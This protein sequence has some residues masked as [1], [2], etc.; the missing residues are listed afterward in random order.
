VIDLYGLQTA[1]REWS[2]FFTKLEAMPVPEK[3]VELQK[4]NW[5]IRGWNFTTAMAK[6]TAAGMKM[7]SQAEIDARLAICQAC[8]YLDRQSTCTVCGCAC[9]ETNQ[10][11][12]KLAIA[13]EKCPMGKWE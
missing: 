7:R 12:N 3:P 10:V 1:M 13:T 6:W 2:E 5:L 4:P 9:V 8:P 11:L